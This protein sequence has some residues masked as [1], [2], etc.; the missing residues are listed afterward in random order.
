MQLNNLMEF[1]NRDCLTCIFVFLKPEELVVGEFVCKRWYNVLKSTSRTSKRVLFMSCFTTTLSLFKWAHT[2]GCPILDIIAC[3]INMYKQGQVDLLEY[4]DKII[5][6]KRG[7]YQHWTEFDFELAA[8]F[9]HVSVMKWLQS[10]YPTTYKSSCMSSAARYNQDE[11]IQYLYAAGCPWHEE[12]CQRLA[13][14]GNLPM[15]Q[16]A[17]AHGCPWDRSKFLFHANQ[18]I[19]GWALTQPD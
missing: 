3:T 6:P 13:I 7:E 12:T 10:R 19:R 1:L 15:I 4:A 9:G 5:L 16:W 8:S 11:M 2:N 14:H 17:R 18:E